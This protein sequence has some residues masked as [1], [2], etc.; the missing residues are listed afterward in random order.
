MFFGLP[1]APGPKIDHNVL[2]LKGLCY[3]GWN[4]GLCG[5]RRNPGRRESDQILRA[6]GEKQE[7]LSQR[8]RARGV[9]VILIDKD[10]N[11]YLVYEAYPLITDEMEFRISDACEET[12][13]LENIEPES[14]R[15]QLVDAMIEIASLNYND[16]GVEGFGGSGYVPVTGDFDGDRLADPPTPARSAMHSIAGGSLGETLW[17][18]LVIYET[19]TSTWTFR[20]SS[21]GYV[22]IPV[23]F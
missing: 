21:L 10:R 14:L 1:E 11:E 13:A 3:G 17:A 19:A 16:S 18:G 2:K 6:R 12:C 20:L 23:M 22:P 8:R 15:I 9:R 4:H 5:S 7:Y